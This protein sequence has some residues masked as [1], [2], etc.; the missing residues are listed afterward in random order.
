M[1]APRHRAGDRLVADEEFRFEHESPACAH[2]LALPARELTECLP[3]AD[4]T[5]MPTASSISA[6]FF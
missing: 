5:S 2:L 3:P 6:T 4:S 1:P